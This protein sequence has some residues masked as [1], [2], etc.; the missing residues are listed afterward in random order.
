M[1]LTTRTRADATSLSGR[2][3]EPGRYRRGGTPH[4]TKHAE[5]RSDAVEIRRLKSDQV[6]LRP[7]IGIDT[8]TCIHISVL[9]REQPK[10]PIYSRF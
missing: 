9:A 5:R 7:K 3:H 1:I 10:A 6:R 4:R 8:C 2:I